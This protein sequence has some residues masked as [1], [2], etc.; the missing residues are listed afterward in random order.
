MKLESPV[1]V[2]FFQ[3]WHFCLKM[4][5]YHHHHQ[6]FCYSASEMGSPFAIVTTFANSNHNQ[7]AQFSSRQTFEYVSQHTDVM[8]VRGHRENQFAIGHELLKESPRLTI[9]YR[10]IFISR[11]KRILYAVLFLKI[12]LLL[13][14]SFQFL[15]DTKTL[16]YT[17]AIKLYLFLGL[18]Q[19]TSQWI[20]I[21]NLVLFIVSLQ[22]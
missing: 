5:H 20:P 13:R 19:K 15:F 10:T 8:F 11:A 7:R 21:K 17:Q 14:I 18:L 16:V 6:D 3:H 9:K 22:K 2:T 1:A 4:E 12:F